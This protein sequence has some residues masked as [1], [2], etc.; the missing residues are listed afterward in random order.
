MRLWKK[1]KRR[2]QPL[3][4]KAL[5][6]RFE[7]GSAL[8]Q[9]EVEVLELVAMGMQNAEI[10]RRLYLS[11]ET[12]K[13]HVRHILSRLGARNRAHAVWLGVVGGWLTTISQD[14]TSGPSP[15]S[16]EM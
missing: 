1:G 15:G 4:R 8:S 12:I 7:E 9:R 11:E 13:T 5:H 10:G 14:K 6:S 2:A 16:P 3:G